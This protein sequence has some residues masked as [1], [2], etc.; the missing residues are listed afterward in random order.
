M[1]PAAPGGGWDQTARSMQQ[2]LVAEKI[3][4]AC[5]SPTCPGA[6]GTRRHRAVRQRRQGRRQP[7]DGQRLRHGGRDPHEQV[8]GH[9][10]PGDADRAPHRARS[11]SIVVP[12]NSPIKN[13]EGPGR[14]REGRH[15]ARSP[16]PA[17]RPAAST[18]SMAAL[19]AKARRR[20]PTKINYIPF[21]GGGESLAAI[22]GGK[23][24]AGISGYGE[25]EGQIKAGKLRA[26]RRDLGEAHRRASTCRPSRSRASTS[27]SPTGARWW[28]LPASRAEQKQGARPTPSTSMV[29]SEAWKDI[30]KQKGWDDAYLSGDAFAEIP[31]EGAGARHRRAEVGRPRE[32]MSE[33]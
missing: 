14:G 12:A 10:R 2:A 22:L 30:L 18:I 3:A 19:F 23:V 11:R 8:A 16:W 5:R 29:K 31:E 33:T 9:A 25:Y 6:G 21:S 24:T 27:C 15:R 7:A 20:R 13:A 1:A 32:V 28:R 17:A 26:H 4:R